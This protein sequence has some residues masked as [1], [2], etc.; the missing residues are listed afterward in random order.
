MM[1]NVVIKLIYILWRFFRSYI[2][3]QCNLCVNH[4]LVEFLAHRTLSMPHVWWTVLVFLFISSL[5][6]NSLYQTLLPLLWHCAFNISSTPLLLIH[7][8][9]NGVWVLSI[10]RFDLWDITHYNSMLEI[11][12]HIGILIKIS[13]YLAGFSCRW[14]LLVSI[15]D[16]NCT[17]SRNFTNR[18]ILIPSRRVPSLD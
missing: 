3:Q 14:L 11:T 15:L 10:A 5:R 18:I 6:C 12:N 4:L 9:C 17:M 7:I 2:V 16:V 8:C 1:W 13:H